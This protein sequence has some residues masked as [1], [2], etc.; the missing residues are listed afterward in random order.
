[1]VL[2]KGDMDE[3]NPNMWAEGRL[4]CLNIPPI[5]VEMQKDTSPIQYTKSVKFLYD[6][7]VD[8]EPI[9]W[10]PNDEEQLQDLKT[11]LSSAPVLSLPDLKK[12]FD[13][14]V[15]VEVGIAYGVLTQDW[16][17]CRKPVAYLS[18]LLDPVARGWPSCVQ[19]IAATATLIED[20]QKLTLRERIRIH[21][22]H[23]VKTVLSQKAPQ[24]VTDSRILKYK[25]ILISTEGL[26]LV[27]SKCLSP[28]QFLIG[29]PLTDLEHDCLEVIEMQMKV[30]EDLE[31]E[32]LPYGRILF[33]DGSS[34]VVA[35]KRASGYAII[36]GQNMQVEEKGKLSSNWSAQCCEIYA[37]KRGLDLLEKDKG[38]I[39]T[40]SQYAFG[41]AH[42]FG[43]IWEERGYLNSKGKN[44]I[45]EE[46]IKLVL[47]SLR[48]PIEIAIVHVKGHQK[49]DT[50]EIKGN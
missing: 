41:I 39:Y 40:D 27:T 6:K 46:L 21:T 24:W 10:T 28:A 15:N 22:P 25:M 8:S 20:T 7:L 48:K 2:R 11:K 36:D 42:T 30:R 43:K 14:F 19:V 29:E 38:T 34:R 4:G 13:L 16:G 44:L 12:G 49:G 45:H 26:E 31:D 35:G 1:M 47:K 3:I 17:G 5:K 9:T 18:K 50:L 33:T 37:L 32:P 23:N